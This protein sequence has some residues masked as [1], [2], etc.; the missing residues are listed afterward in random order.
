ML[1][2]KDRMSRPEGKSLALSLRNIYETLAVSLPTVVDAA[3]GRVTKEVC[4]ERLARWARNIVHNA[5]IELHVSGR[6]NLEPGRTYLVMSNHQSLYD[7]PILFEIAGPNIRMIAK[8]ELFH[9]PVFGGA[10]EASGFIA[11]DRRDRNAAIRS[12]DKARALLASGTHVWI[13]PEGTRS[14]TGKLLPFKKGAFYLA[15]EAGLPILPLTLS[16]TR[17]ALAAKGVRSSPGAKVRATLHPHVDPRPY[18]ARGRPGRQQLMD[19]VRQTLE[20]AL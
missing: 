8:R 5:R 17:D 1:P 12:L 15:F 10:L 3:R 11:I 7:I 20:S 13:A 14:L 18:A 16:G 4:D 19:E 9:V 2:E 6:E